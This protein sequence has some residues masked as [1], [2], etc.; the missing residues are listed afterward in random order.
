MHA[1]REVSRM[2]NEQVKRL[3]KRGRQPY[4]PL[5]MRPRLCYGAQQ[6][7]RMV[8]C[9]FFAVLTVLTLCAAFVSGGAVSASASPQSKGAHSEAAQ[10]EVVANKTTWHAIAYGSASV[11]AAS[12][13]GGVAGCANLVN[14][15]LWSRSGHRLDTVV[16]ALDLPEKNWLSGHRGIDVAAVTGDRIR[17]PAAGAVTFAGSVAG[18]SELS[19][20]TDSGVIVTFEPAMSVP[21]IATTQKDAA[22]SDGGVGDGRST[23]PQSSVAVAAGTVIGE[24]SGHSDHCDGECV[25]WSARRNGRYVDPVAALSD[26]HLVLKPWEGT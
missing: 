9:F 5:R 10:N 23:V 24:I 18:K 17:A 19:F 2:W 15:P 16:G 14:W 26:V 6:N 4:A 7:R 21:D 22:G 20:T 1:L 12:Q 13:F 11:G 3:R 8:M 25:H